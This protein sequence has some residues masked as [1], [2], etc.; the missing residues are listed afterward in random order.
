YKKS[1]EILKEIQDIDFG[2]IGNVELTRI[3]FSNLSLGKL[4]N[5]AELSLIVNKLIAQIEKGL[6]LDLNNNIDRKEE[7]LLILKIIY[8]I[9]PFVLDDMNNTV[10]FRTLYD[11]SLVIYNYFKLNSLNDSYVSYLIN[12]F[13]R[14]AFLF[15]EPAM[16]IIYYDEAENYFK[17]NNIL[18]ELIVTYASKA[19]MLIDLGSYGEAI[20]YCNLA[21]NLIYDK[22]IIIPLKEKIY[23]NLYIAEFLKSEKSLKNNGDEIALAY[24]TIDKLSKLLTVEANG[25]NHVILTNLASLFLYVDDI[26][27]YEKIKTVIQLSLDCDDVSNIND[28]SINDFYRYHF[29]W[30]EFFKNLKM[31]KFDICLN[32]CSSLNGFYPSIFHNHKKM[33]LRVEAA[34]YLAQKK[35]NPTS[36]ELCL[37]FLKYAQSNKFYESRALLLSDLQFTLFE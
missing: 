1:N 2:V 36:K 32:I 12:V 17:T 19:G 11:K 6:E 26:D 30:F 13:N 15:T 34:L 5:E 10:L 28:L 22:K 24:Y 20:K 7:K 37:N 21:L 16:A 4:A 18:E 33:D 25:K 14:K 35:L 29:G 9:S 23:N 8:N 31:H 3:K 27:N